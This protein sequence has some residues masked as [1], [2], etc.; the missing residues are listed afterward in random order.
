MPFIFLYR[1]HFCRKLIT[2]GIQKVMKVHCEEYVRACIRMSGYYPH[3]GIQW[4][5]VEILCWN[6]DLALIPCLRARRAIVSGP[7]GCRG[8]S[9]HIQCMQN[10]PPVQL[11]LPCLQPV[12]PQETANAEDCIKG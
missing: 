2:V 4:T 12:Q 6:N 3:K 8:L 7:G 5:P 9:V 1:K 11:T 10:C